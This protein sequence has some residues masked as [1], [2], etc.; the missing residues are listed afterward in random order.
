VLGKIGFNPC[1]R[2]TCPRTSVQRRQPG[3]ER[4]FQ[5]LFSWNLPSD[6]AGVLRGARH[7]SFNPCFR[8]TCPRT[9]AAE[10]MG[11][12]DLQ[13]SILVFVELALGPR[14]MLPDQDFSVEFQSLFSW[15]LPSDLIMHCATFRRWRQ[16]QS[17]FS[18]NLPSDYRPTEELTFG[19]V[20]S[21]LVFVELALGPVGT[22][23]KLPLHISFNP[24]F[25]GTCPR[26]AFWWGGVD[27]CLS[28][29][30][31]VFVELALGPWHRH[32]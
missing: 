12:L 7:A 4:K 9:T 8:G 3:G 1:F 21:I 18:W 6:G 30:I 26:T 20:V 27:L 24:C 28:V 16:F 15:N 10:R 31:L 32:R 17:L 29:S 5:S 2:G 23:S 14:S 11:T 25:R 13:V 22:V 19:V